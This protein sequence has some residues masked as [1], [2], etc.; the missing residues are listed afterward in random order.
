MVALGREMVTADAPAFAAELGGV[1]QRLSGRHLHGYLPGVAFGH[2]APCVRG[3]RG[4]RG[5]GASGAQTLFLCAARPDVV[6]LQ[7]PG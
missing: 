7:G 2:C 4:R 1:E 5:Y 3:V 6:G